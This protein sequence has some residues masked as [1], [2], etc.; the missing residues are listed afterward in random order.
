MIVDD[1][2]WYSMI[3][4]TRSRLTANYHSLSYTI[5]D[6]HQLS[7]ALNRFKIVIIVDD[8]WWLSLDG[9]E[10]GHYHRLS[11]TVWSGFTSWHWSCR[12][13]TLYWNVIHRLPIFPFHLPPLSAHH[14]CK[15]L[16]LPLPCSVL[17]TVRLAHFPCP[18]KRFYR[19][20]PVS[21]VECGWDRIDVQQLNTTVLPLKL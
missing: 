4:E 3:V 8:S 11:S 9:N 10:L 5:I 14:T 13:N 16:S 21:Q 15:N 12:E 6:F 20:P 7:F 17:T 18:E 2:W 1:G 19:F